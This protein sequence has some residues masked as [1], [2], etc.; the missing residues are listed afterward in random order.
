MRELART[1]PYLRPYRRLAGLSVG[2]LI[3]D[4]VV[5]L[6]APWTMVLLMDYVVRGLPPPDLLVDVFGEWVLDPGALLVFVVVAMILIAVVNHGLT[7][8]NTYIQARIEQGMILRFRS[9]LFRHVQRLSLSFHDAQRSGDFMYRI[10]YSSASV[11]EVP[12]MIPQLAQAALTLVGMSII[13]FSLNPTLGVVSAMVVP[14][15]WLTV[16]TYARRVEP[17]LT[18]VRS[19][20]GQSLT[21]IQEAMSMLRVIIAFGREDYE[22]RRFKEQGEIAV[23]ARVRLTLLQMSFT[24]AVGVTVAT[25]TAIVLGVGA[26]QIVEQRLTIGQLLVVMA[27]IGSVYGPLSM[28]ANSTGPIQEQRVNLR[29]AFALLDT[30][31]D[32]K[33]HPRAI[34]IGRSRGHVEYRGVGFHYPGRTDTLKDISF[35]A[36]PGQTVAIVGP[37]G[38]G[39]TTLISLLPRF[40]DPQEG[41]L[42]L[43]GY[44]ISHLTL[45]SLRQQFS[46]VLQEPLLFSTSIAENIR[47]GRLEATHDEVI[48]AA[49]AANAHDFIERLPD[50]YDTAVGERGGR[51]SGGERQRIAVARAFLKDA[52]ILILDE[53]TSSVDSKTELAILDALD[54]LILGRTSFLIAHRLSTVRHADLI[55]VLDHGRIVERGTHEELVAREGLYRQMHDAQGREHR[56]IEPARIPILGPGM[57]TTALAPLEAVPGRREEQS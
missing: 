53:P 42:L 48:R 39:K 8:V 50:G 31:P 24:M 41:S 16:R 47:Y 40:Y 3:L 17:R 10:N 19:L 5:D 43:D 27:Y 38:A 1:L 9:D 46:I 23:K 52:P 32:I 11:G 34:P 51:L 13:V 18:H 35:V 29:A 57:T 21:M 22:H 36:E 20:E 12:M 15:L 55:L 6:L 56:K 7:V 2:I 44:H 25:G 30:E 37:T 26:F 4:A 49:R 45:E 54:R 28:I 14:V 33:D